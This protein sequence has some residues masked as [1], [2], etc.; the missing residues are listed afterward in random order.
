MSPRGRGTHHPRGTG[1]AG[2]GCRATGLGCE[3]PSWRARPW[4][5]ATSLLRTHR[6]AKGVQALF[7]LMF[8]WTLWDG[9]GLPFLTGHTPCA[10]ATTAGMVPASSSSFW[11]FPM[12]QP[13]RPVLPEC[14]SIANTRWLP[15]SVSVSI[16]RS[17]GGPGSLAPAKPRRPRTHIWFSLPRCPGKQTMRHLPKPRTRREGMCC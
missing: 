16:R 11:K 8:S 13:W 7:S 1:R 12:P 9:A 6:S 2:E 17:R 10:T 3:V 5:A 15:R 4:A 14:F